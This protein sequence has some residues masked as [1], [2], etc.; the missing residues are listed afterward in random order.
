MKLTSYS[1]A[2]CDEQDAYPRTAVA[3]ASADDD[4]AAAVV[5]AAEVSDDEIAEDRG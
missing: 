4:A 5:D 2:A 1:D 3:A